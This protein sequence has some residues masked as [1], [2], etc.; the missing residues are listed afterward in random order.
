MKGAA[1]LG[2]MSLKNLFLQIYIVV[3]ITLAAISDFYIVKAIF[4]LWI[5]FILMD[6]DLGTFRRHIGALFPLFKGVRFT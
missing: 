3:T 4:V 1:L 2:D 5:F 6:P